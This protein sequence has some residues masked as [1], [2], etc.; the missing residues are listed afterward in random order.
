MSRADRLTAFVERFKEKPAAWGED[1]CSAAPARWVAEETGRVVDYPVYSSEA[2]ALALKQEA[3][4]LAPI[5]EDRLGRVGMF[6][7]FDEPRLGD[8]A[9][10][11][12]RLYG[13]I[14]GIVAHGRVVL[15]RK[16]S[17]GWHPFGPVRQ[18]VKVWAM[19]EE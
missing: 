11:D 16:D 8:V 5:W 18:F 4:G 13:E 7:R 12:T 6:E 15:I 19:P 1:D 10:V 14:G 3:G 9:I 2:E 17:G